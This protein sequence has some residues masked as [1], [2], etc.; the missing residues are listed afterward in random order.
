MRLSTG[1]TANNRENLKATNRSEVDQALSLDGIL[2]KRTY[3]RMIFGGFCG[4]A[5]NMLCSNAN[6]SLPDRT[7]SH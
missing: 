4:L 6:Y 1:A 3:W 5:N 2:A 7:V